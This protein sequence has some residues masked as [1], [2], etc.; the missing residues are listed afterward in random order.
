MAA[1][2]AEL[3]DP[4]ELLRRIVEESRR[5][6]GSD[7]AHLTRMR[8]DAQALVPVVVTGELDEVAESALLALRFPVMG[9]I[10]GLAAGLG[11]AVWTNDY[12]NDARIPHEPGDDE[13]AEQ[14]GLCSMAAVP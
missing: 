12:V 3:R 6:L 10:N 7:G 5:L 1:R 13:L 8:E 14:L 2:I 11:Q 4:D 9:G